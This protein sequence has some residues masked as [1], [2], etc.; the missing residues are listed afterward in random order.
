MGFQRSIRPWLTQTLADALLEALQARPSAALLVSPTVHL[1]TDVLNPTPTTPASAY[2]EA[3]FAGYAPV[4]LT[5]P[6]VGPVNAA[7]NTRALEEDAEFIASSALSSTEN[8]TGYWVDNGASSPT[9]TYMA[10]NFP[11]PDPIVR[12]GDFV[13]LDVIF[14]IFE[15]PAAQ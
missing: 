10:E 5:L 3:T 13:S 12:P 7:L 9:V 14:P 15:N 11:N 6:M 2:T 4:T 8:I 1:R